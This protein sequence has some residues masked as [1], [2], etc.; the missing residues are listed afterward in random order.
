MVHMLT[1]DRLNLIDD[2]LEIHKTVL[3]SLYQIG[4]DYIKFYQELLI[5]IF[6]GYLAVTGSII[7]FWATHV[8]F[9]LAAWGLWIPIIIG[10]ALIVICTLATCKKW[11]K[12][13]DR[14]MK[15]ILE[16]L[17][18]QEYQRPASASYIPTLWIVILTCSLISLFCLGLF[19][20]IL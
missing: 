16:N 15:A 11:H 10:F 5:K 20:H 9:R 12:H 14:Q 7:A 13:N 1:E 3:V 17:G 2:R 8:E 4:W 19:F 6:F 18:L